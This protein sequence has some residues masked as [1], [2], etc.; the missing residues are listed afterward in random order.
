MHSRNII[1][2]D[3]KPLNILLTK[4]G[5]RQVLKLGDLWDSKSLPQ[6]PKHTLKIAGTPL[7]MAP[8]LSRGDPFDSRVIVHHSKFNRLIYGH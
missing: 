3:I 5:T 1:H 2:R 6:N 7:Y 8:E 4:Q